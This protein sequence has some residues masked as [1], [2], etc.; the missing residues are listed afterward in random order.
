MPTYDMLLLYYK[1]KRRCEY[2]DAILFLGL[3]VPGLFVVI[4]KMKK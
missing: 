4:K 1:D 2:D 3:C